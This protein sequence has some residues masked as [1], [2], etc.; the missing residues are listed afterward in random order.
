[1]VNP[2]NPPVPHLNLKDSAY[3]EILDNLYD[4]LYFVSRERVIVYWNK[5]AERIS[6][7]SA[8]EVVGRSCYDNILM[9]MDDEG[10]VLCTGLCP[11]AATIADGEPREAEVYLHHRDGHPV[12]VALRISPLKDECGNIIGAVELF[13]DISNHAVNNLKIKEL[14]QLA[15]IDNLTGIANRNYVE[16]ELHGR[17]HEHNRFGIPFGLLFIDID[18]FKTFNDTYGHDVG[19]K[20]LKF[21]AKTFITNGRPFDLYGR[22]GGEEF[23]GIIRNI[24]APD[25]QVLGNRMRMLI[26]SSHIR[27]RGARL[28]VTG[29]VGATLVR[30]GDTQASLIKRADGLLYASKAAGRNRLTLG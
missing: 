13:T 28:Q 8:D 17:F 25:L 23:V 1:M 12:P 29:S 4:G 9:H 7:F 19:D 14:E 3:K 5:A 22:W 24:N 26:A 6:G 15:F 20:V 18:H 16:R 11:L 2:P 27:H 21:V 10:Y 30:Q